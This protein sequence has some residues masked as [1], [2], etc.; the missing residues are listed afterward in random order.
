[1]RPLFF[2]LLLS[3]SGAMAW[4]FPQYHDISDTTAAT[5]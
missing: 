3:A 2:L 1:M 4:A 5:P